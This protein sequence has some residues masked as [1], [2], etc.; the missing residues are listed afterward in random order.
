[1]NFNVIDW[2]FYY[3]KTSLNGWHFGYLLLYEVPIMM[4]Y[5]VH[6]SCSHKCI[7]IFTYF[8]SLLLNLYFSVYLNIVKIIQK[9]V[10]LFGLIKVL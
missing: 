5:E 1:M 10:N 2:I 6:C 7:E 8:S 9:L 3:D 4:L